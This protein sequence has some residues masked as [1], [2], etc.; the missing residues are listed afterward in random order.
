MGE[1]RSIFSN[2]DNQAPIH[3]V[4]EDSNFVKLINERLPFK[5]SDLEITEKMVNYLSSKVTIKFLTNILEKIS[6]KKESLKKKEDKVSDF[7]IN[8]KTQEKTTKRIITGIT[9]ANSFS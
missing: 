4:F 8:Y 2:L 5:L 3:L 9:I 6:K 1:V 7:K